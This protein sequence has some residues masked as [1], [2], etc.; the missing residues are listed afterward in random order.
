MSLAQW[1]ETLRS[2]VLGSLNLHLCL[3]KDLDFSIMLSSVCGIIGASGQSNY[4]FGCAYQ[5]ALSCYRNALGHKTVSID[6]G[7]V[8][9]VG[10]TAENQSIGAFMKSLGLQGISEGFLHQLLGYYCDPERELHNAT[11]AQIVVGIMAEEELNRSE[12]V[13]PRFYSRPLFRHLSSIQRKAQI[14]KAHRAP[15]IVRD[16][17]K[18]EEEAGS[19][20]RISPTQNQTSLSKAICSRLSKILAVD[21][22][23]IDAAKPL[24][25]YGVDSLVAMEVRVWFKEVQ[26]L[27]V[28]VFDILSNVSIDELAGK[29]ISRKH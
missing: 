15:P 18:V 19:H 25:T 26:R 23:D 10:Y 29:I 7:T 13:R 6:L 21:L 20:N 24:H 4:A 28:T 12:L 17:D 1:T 5:D 14:Q 22:Q 8:E 27:D 3:P 2:K 16:D 9:G 11:A